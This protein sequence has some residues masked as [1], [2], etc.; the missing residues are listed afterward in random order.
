MLQKHTD[1][2]NPMAKH[3]F[4]GLA[5]LLSCFCAHAQFYTSGSDATSLKWMHFKT[6][7]YEIIYPQGMDSLALSYA[8]SLEKYSDFISPGL[9]QKRK[10]PV[11][12]R[13]RTA[14]SNGLVVLPPLRMELYT[15]PDPYDP[16]PTPW[17]EHLSAHETR[18]VDQM[19]ATRRKPWNIVRI[20]AGGLMDGLFVAVNADQSMYEGDAVAAETRLT[21]SG[22]GRTADFLEYY[23]VSFAEGDRRNFYRWRYGS[24]KLYTPDYYRAGYIAMAGMGDEPHFTGLPGRKFIRHF[25]MNCDSL[26]EAWARDEQARAP[27]TPSHQLIRT[28]RYY[29]EY[30]SLTALNGSIYAIE[31]GL[32]K[33]RSMVKIDREGNVERLGTFSSSASRLRSSQADGR[34]YWSEYR[35]DVRWEYHSHS[36]IFYL[37]GNGQRRRLTDGG[38]LYNPAPSPDGR[39]VAAAEYSENGK[40]SVC[41]IDAVS[42]EVLER[43]PAPDGVQPVEFCWAGDRL[44]V[45]TVDSK[46]FGICQADGFKPLLEPDAVKLKG[47]YSDGDSIM[48]T[49]DLTGVNELYSLDPSTGKTSRLTSS[50]FG[51]SEF[52]SMGDSLYFCILSADGRMV[53]SASLDSLLSCEADFTAAPDYPLAGERLSSA[54]TD[55]SAAGSGQ[56]GDPALKEAAR[57]RGSLIP[58]IHSWLPVYV[59]FDSVDELSAYSLTS[60]IGLGASVFFQNV[61][62][63]VYGNAAI[64]PFQEPTGKWRTEYDFNL[65]TDALYTVI[66]ARFNGNVR[67]AYV[68]SLIKD[69]A[70]SDAISVQTSSAPALNLSL[71]AYVPLN[72]SRHGLSIG[73]VPSVSA[74]LSNDLIGKPVTGGTMVAMK[75]LVTGVRGYVME[76]IPSSRVYPRLGIGA[77]IGGSTHPGTLGMINP[78][79]YAFVYGYLPG[80]AQTQGIKLSAL[81]DY[82]PGNAPL[83]W[84][85]VSCGPR[86]FSSSTQSLVSSFRTK[87]KFSLDYVIPF[88]AVDWSFL[89]PVAYIRNFELTPHAD[90]SLF[91]DGQGMENLYSM[92]ADLCVRL[93]NLL[94]IPFDTRIG[95]SYNYNGGS[96]FPSLV[97]TWYEQSP[98][99]VS[100]LLS[101][102][103]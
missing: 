83:M 58:K 23:R 14:Y 18:H 87:M 73:L 53:H 59:D 36:D 40:C 54:M 81:L 47:L 66:E 64:H 102:D 77:E 19:L 43:L 6:G 11:I 52:C 79:M 16:L 26:A 92:G 95:I 35:P 61:L 10:I 98:H 32:T 8:A 69:E 67:E 33:A 4:I 42:G 56:S 9:L 97:N 27:F 28:P 29:T 60:S 71:K 2:R 84:N 90:L 38:S 7:H 63:N 12:L 89:S 5:A 65:T 75:R 78:E 45:S 76:S 24:Q 68:Y 70:G 3:I 1:L 88:G 13:N 93:G 39:A 17:Q 51:A 50:R 99:S 101:I 15:T 100:L 20:I 55:Q 72:F 44:Y 96:I 74:N 94:W 25:E 57:Y 31:K 49:A 30:T 82:M 22:R 41:I 80:I 62:G 86:G 85:S 21:V 91:S 34:I 103:L 46:G 37:D 48:F